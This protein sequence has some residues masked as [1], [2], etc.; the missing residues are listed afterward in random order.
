MIRLAAGLTTLLRWARFADVEVTPAA[1]YRLAVLVSCSVLCSGLIVDYA[2]APSDPL[3]VGDVAPRTIKAPFTF[4]YQDDAAFKQAR[5]DA[6][7]ATPP[8]FTHQSTLSD[9]LVA[10]ID[11][12]F[13][14]ARG[15]R[16]EFIKIRGEGLEEG[17]VAELTD[18]D[19]KEIADE[20]RLNLGVEVESGVDALM[21]VEFS[22]EAAEFAKTLIVDAMRE[23]IVRDRGALPTDGRAIEVIRLVGGGAENEEFFVAD[24]TQILSP[25]GGRNKVRSG[26]LNSKTG[27]LSAE[28]KDAASVIAQA[29]VRPNL[30]YA[31][32]EMEER[33]QQ[34]EAS[35]LLEIK[36]VKRGAILF[37]GGDPVTAESLQVYNALQARQGEQIL[38]REIAAISA[39]LM[40]LFASL[41]SFGAAK[42]R[43]FSI[44]VRDVA[45]V[46]S[47]LIMTAF[48]ARFIVASSEGIAE[49]VGFEAEARSVWFLVPV[50]GLAMLVRQLLSIGWAVVFSVAAAALCGLIMDLQA[51]PVIFFLLSGVAAAGAVEGTRERIAVLYA[52]AWVG[53]INAVFVLSIH[54][55]QL[56]VAESELSMATTMRPLWSMVFA[57]IGGSVL[58]AAL[59][60]VLV[61]AFEAVGFVTDYRLM[62][63]ANLNHPMLMQLLLRAPGSYH[64]SVNV[65]MLSEAGCEAIGANALR[66]KVA[67]YFHDIG[68]SQKPAYFVENQ[69]DGINKHNGLDPYTSAK[70]IISHVTDGGRM[71]KEHR[72]PKPIIDNIYMHHGTGIIQYFYIQA[73]T[74]AEDPSTVDDAAF[75]YPGPKPNTREAGVI[76]LADKVEAA[77]RT[78]KQPDEQKIRAL[79]SKIVSSVMADGQF[80]ECPLTFKEIYTVADVFVSVLMGIHHQRIE[81]PDAPP[82]VGTPAATTVPFSA[83][84]PK[85]AIITLEL[86]PGKEEPLVTKRPELKAIAGG[87]SKQSKAELSAADEESS[88]VVDYEAIEHLPK[89]KA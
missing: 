41:Y 81:Y 86:T 55:V 82:I 19:R 61:P 30:T 37:R 47:L 57:F 25:D 20:F 66:S 46:A 27:D 88:D 74:E 50:A 39:F 15:R 43:P 9:D 38:W 34:A 7:E 79:I 89:G 67:S 63:L 4:T 10:R 14:T 22:G 17:E 12:A 71:A 80:S 23:M 1:L 56:L 83:E 32:I 2:R 59:Y 52:A 51:L 31:P 65:G 48:L 53:V 8:V 45:A 68:K 35:V 72:L 54:F 73:L 44:R 24:H 70:I 69:R 42:L 76:M 28:V 58:S 21:N 33:R 5:L 26:L 60:L 77:T 16:L 36:T 3:K 40:L 18:A 84:P 6:V 49:L 64:H 85:H 11:N 29:L 75:R 62:E 78:I 13:D 87:Q